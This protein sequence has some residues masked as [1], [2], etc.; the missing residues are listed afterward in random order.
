MSIQIVNGSVVAYSTQ[1]YLLARTKPNPEISTPDFCNSFE[2][3]TKPLCCKLPESFYN[4][5]DERKEEEDSMPDEM[6]EG[7]SD[8]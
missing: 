1:P 8:I 3:K 6:G 4:W 5:A 7:I 2:A